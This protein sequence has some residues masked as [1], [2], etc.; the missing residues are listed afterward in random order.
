MA[1]S[2]EN[3]TTILL[4]LKDYRVGDEERVVVETAIKGKQRKCPY[5]GSAKLQLT[6]HNQKRTNLTE[7]TS[8][9]EADLERE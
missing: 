5:C 9:L 7:F 6:I 8:T 1:K 4:G 2:Q 3:G